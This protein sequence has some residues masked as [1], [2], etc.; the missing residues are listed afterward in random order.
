MPFGRHVGGI[1][2]NPSYV[3]PGMGYAAEKIVDAQ[4]LAFRPPIKA[5]EETD[6]ESRTSAKRRSIP[7]AS[8]LRVDRA[9]KCE[10]Y[11]KKPPDMC[12]QRS[13]PLVVAVGSRVGTE[14]RYLQLLCG[15]RG[16]AAGAEAGRNKWR[17]LLLRRS[18][19]GILTGR[20]PTEAGY[21]GG[22]EF[23]PTARS[24]CS[25][26]RSAFGSC[27]YRDSG[28]EATKWCGVT[29]EGAALVAYP[30]LVATGIVA[31]CVL[32]EEA[33]SPEQLLARR[34]PHLAVAQKVPGEP[35]S[36]GALCVAIS[37]MPGGE[38]FL[39]EAPEGPVRQIEGG[40][41]R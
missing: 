37:M 31:E 30:A 12:I 39:S 27:R 8:N 28:L 29:P 7:K 20:G 22:D 33:R 1:F 23:W 13:A 36:P 26:A 4:L 17:L 2:D 18:N 24:G 14:K 10:T 34:D 40:L 19:R 16:R 21:G 35:S 32:E 3:L 38:A 15:E 6:M 25:A 41:A 9:K 11:S 5:E